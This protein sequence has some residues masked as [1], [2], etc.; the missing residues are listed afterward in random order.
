MTFDPDD[1]LN[2]A[3]PRRT[4]IVNANGVTYPVTGADTVALSSSLSLSNTLHIHTQEIIGR[5]TKRGGLYYVDDFSPGMVL[6]PK[7][8]RAGPR[9]I[10]SPAQ[11]FKPQNEL[12]WDIRKL[13][14][15]PARVMDHMPREANTHAKR[16]KKGQNTPALYIHAY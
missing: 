2:T 6:I 13:V 12:N 7:N 5:G 8:S 9:L 4:F 16:V 11:I 15:A 10:P 14:G 1:F 3:Q